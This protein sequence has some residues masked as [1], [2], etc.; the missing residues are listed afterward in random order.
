MNIQLSNNKSENNQRKKE[1]KKLPPINSTNRTKKIKNTSKN[2]KNENNK[3]I[4]IEN[5]KNIEKEIENNKN[6]E[7]ENNDNDKNII[8]SNSKKNLDSILRTKN[9][10]KVQIIEE[11]DPNINGSNSPLLFGKSNINENV[12]NETNLSNNNNTSIIINETGIIDQK[13]N[14]IIPKVYKIIIVFRNE[15]F[16]I[17]AK[18]DTTIK[19]LRLSISKLINLETNQIGMIFNDKEIGTSNDDKTISTY[20]NFKKMRSRPIIYIRKKCVFNNIGDTSFGNYLFKK[21]FNNKVK[22]TNFPSITDIR[23]TIDEDINNVIQNFFKNNSSFGEVNE[24]NQYKL[25]YGNDNTDGKDNN[26]YIIGF[27]SPD[28]AFDFNR[29]ISSLKLINPIYKDVKSNII[30]TK[31]RSVDNKIKHL[32]NNNKINIKGN[33]RYGID[34]NLDETDLTKRNSEILKLIRNNFLQKNYLKREKN[35][36]QVFINA[37]GPYLSSIDKDRIEEK[38]NKKKWICPEGFISCVGKYSGI[39]L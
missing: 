17:T 6:M 36:S 3:N 23:L 11:N 8:K 25:E 20:F 5:N 30:S 31:K 35:K 4:D 33:L 12:K 28:L 26:T 1:K 21:N 19:N 38:E 24:N 18:P 13:K 16:Y 27:P 7:N 37:T 39:Q 14:I 15:D 10:K 9:K 34:Y 32:S 22:V 29:Y 2:K